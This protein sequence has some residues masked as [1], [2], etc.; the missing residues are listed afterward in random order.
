MAVNSVDGMMSMYFQKVHG[1]YVS[2]NP[3]LAF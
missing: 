1:E 3:Y 2:M